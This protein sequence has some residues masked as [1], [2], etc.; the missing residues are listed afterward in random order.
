[1]QWIHYKG[2]KKNE[3]KKFFKD[4]D[5]NKYDYLIDVFGGSGWLSLYAK[6]QN[7]NIKIILNDLDSELFDYYHYIKTDMLKEL[8]DFVQ[9]NPNY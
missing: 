6:M 8:N 5:F 1:M 2:N 7:P 4:V 3:L 9:N